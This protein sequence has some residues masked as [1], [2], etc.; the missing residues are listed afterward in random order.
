MGPV[1]PPKN[2]I[3]V[4]TQP[5]VVHVPVPVPVVIH[6]TAG[7]STTNELGELFE[8]LSLVKNARVSKYFQGGVLSIG[9]KTKYR[10]SITYIGGATRNIFI[11]LKET[12]MFNNDD[13]NF[14]IRM[15]YVPRGCSESILDNSDFGTRLI[16]V[17]SSNQ[18]DFKPMITVNNVRKNTIIGRIQQP[19]VCPCCCKDANYEIFPLYQGN[20]CKYTVRTNGFQCSYCCCGD[21]CCAEGQTNFI[22]F[23]VAT[24]GFAGNIL[25]RSFNQARDD[26][27]NY[28]IDFPDDALPE[29]KILLICNAI[30]IDNITYKEKGKN[31]K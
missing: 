6:T 7:V 19:R 29:D 1:K 12:E 28:D 15:R 20:L 31:I 2:Y 26:Y 27:V 14:N 21:C 23:N 9:Q 22:I 5:P 24:N 30:G 11:C 10:V 18:H 13:C 16:D 8:D 25:K 4:P 3:P 17:I